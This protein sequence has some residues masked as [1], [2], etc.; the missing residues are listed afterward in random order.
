VQFTPT[1]MRVEAD[2]AG[3]YLASAGL[4]RFHRTFTVT[5][6]DQFAVADTIETRTP[7]AIE[8]YLHADVPVETQA[9]RYLVGGGPAPLAVTVDAPTGS[10]VTTEKTILMAPGKPGSITEGPQEQRGFHL[11]LQTAPSTAVTIRA[12]LVAGGT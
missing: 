1:G 11:M 6:A 5:G 3:A 4:V 8:W 9:G 7:K 12:T 2:A 10:R